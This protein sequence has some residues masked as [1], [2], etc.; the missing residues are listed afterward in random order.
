LMAN[1]FQIGSHLLIHSKLKAQMSERVMWN[2]QVKTGSL[3]LGAEEI[4][5][6]KTKVD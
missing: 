2:P 5:P 4:S 1:K 3:T 6:V